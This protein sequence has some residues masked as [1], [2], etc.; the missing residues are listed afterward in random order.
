MGVVPCAGQILLRIG[1][2][3]GLVAVVR[4]G[5]GRCG[6][7]HSHKRQLADCDDMGT[8][9]TG[10]GVG[11]CKGITRMGLMWERGATRPR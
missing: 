9:G 1:C 8:R 6:R 7:V 3:L 4:L 10:R 5:W 11:W 2:G